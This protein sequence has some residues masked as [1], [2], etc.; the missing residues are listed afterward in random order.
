MKSNKIYIFLVMLVATLT[1]TACFDDQGTETFYG[2]NQ[3]EFNAGNLPNG[4]AATQVRSSPTQTNVVEIQLNR[5]STS[6]TA[7]VTINLEVDPTSTAV[8]GV[9]YRFDVTSVTIPAGEFVVKVPV[10]ILTGNIEPTETPNLVLKMASV[11]GAD[12]SSNYGKLTVLIRVVCPSAISVATDKWKATGTSGF[13]TF[14][15]DV[16]VTPLAGGRYVI[17]DISAGL[18]FSFGFTT[19]QEVIY[20]D[21]CNK[22]TFVQIRTTEFDITAPV[23][24]PKVGSWN[25]ATKTM[26]VYWSD[27][28]NG[29][30]GKTV[31][32]KQ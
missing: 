32:V 27:V 6:A 29:I 18:Y 7:P 28:P 2:G 22:L 17:S 20:S 10:T 12:I 5:V 25:A 8:S 30:N 15:A 1:V 14:T 21:N 16:T 24:E 11:T 23:V 13:G 3:V 4:L 31:L 19:T 9:H 26:T